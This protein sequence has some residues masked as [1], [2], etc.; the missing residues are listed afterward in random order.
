MNKPGVYATCS[1][2]IFARPNIPSS[3]N[4]KPLAKE[5]G[6]SFNVTSARALKDDSTGAR[7]KCRCAVIASKSI[8]PVFISQPNTPNISV[9]RVGTTSTEISKPFLHN[10]YEPSFGIHLGGVFAFFRLTRENGLQTI[11]SRGQRLCAYSQRNHFGRIAGC[12]AVTDK[13]ALLMP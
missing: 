5:I 1:S 4:A 6:S 11:Q 10:L 3:T 12:V 13:L 7:N 9:Q 2:L 8:T